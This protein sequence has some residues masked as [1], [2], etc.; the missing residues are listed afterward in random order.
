MA[1]TEVIP[2][3]MAYPTPKTSVPTVSREEVLSWSTERV[4]GRDYVLV[5]VRRTD[6]EV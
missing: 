5:D 1:G 3:H 4:A 6:F 2:W